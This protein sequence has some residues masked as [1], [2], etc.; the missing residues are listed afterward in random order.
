MARPSHPPQSSQDVDRDEV[1]T[2]YADL[3]AAKDVFRS[4]DGKV[5]KEGWELAVSVLGRLDDQNAA[6][7]KIADVLDAIEFQDDGRVDKVL[8]L[9][10]NLG[11]ETQARG[12]AEVRL[13]PPPPKSPTQTNHNPQ[14]YADTLSASPPTYGPTLLYYARAHA[15]Q[16]LKSTISL[17]ISLSLLHSAAFP[18]P[19]TLDPTLAS[20]LSTER[21]ALVSLAAADAE[22]ATLLSDQLSGYATV[23]RFYNLR[24]SSLR[25]EEQQQ[26]RRGP[27]E[28]KRQAA[29]AL[30]TL[31]LSASDCLSGGLFDPAVAASSVVPVEALLALLG[32]ALPFLGQGKRVFTRGQVWVLLR[33]VED[34][35]TAPARV[36]ERGEGLVG[37]GLRAYRG[38]V[39]WR[40]SGEGLGGSS[41]DMLASSSEGMLK[42]AEA[43]GEGE[44]VQRQWDWRR[45]L[46]AVAGADVG[47]KEVLGLMR[48][49]L[50]REVARGWGGVV[51]W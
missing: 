41:W 3:L 10:S 14:R 2:S 44:E 51:N 23:R 20:L 13:P 38:E 42:S 27:L 34:L 43:G 12:I 28:R 6:Q 5:E 33:V 17:L 1:L 48:T 24:D 47:C 40:G 35:D 49:A 37:A 8:E 39:F 21:S 36:R 22:A 4:S 32:E 18:L 7:Q 30:T 16:K 19:S 45:G 29:T 9:C 31:I 50:A 26:Q 46:D 25:R 11:L 15:P